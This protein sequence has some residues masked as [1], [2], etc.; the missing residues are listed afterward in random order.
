[1]IFNA[2]QR[3]CGGGAEFPELDYSNATPRFPPHLRASPATHRNS[4]ILGA[5][6]DRPPGLSPA[7]V[8]GRVAADRVSPLHERRNQSARMLRVEI[9]AP[10]INGSGITLWT[11]R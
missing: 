9:D 4:L 11:P 2:E 6:C 1:M 8:R 3:R 10:L 7:D 5:M